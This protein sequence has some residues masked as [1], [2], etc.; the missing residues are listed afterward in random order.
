MAKEAKPIEYPWDSE[1]F[2][3]AWKRWK[4]YKKI[5]HRFTYKSSVTEQAGLHRLCALSKTDEKVAI[6][7]I[8]QAIA[9][10]H[11]GLFPLTN[12]TQQPISK[13]GAMDFAKRISGLK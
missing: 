12:G 3:A 6:A 4:D 5:E 9:N 1:E 2:K 8:D 10:T 11:K 13:G 7:I